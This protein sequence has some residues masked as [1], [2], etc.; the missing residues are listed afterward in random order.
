MGSDVGINMNSRSPAIEARFS[1]SPRTAANRLTKT[2]SFIGSNGFLVCVCLIGIVLRAVVYLHNRPFWTDEA[3]LALNIRARSAVDLFGKLDYCQAA[4][5]GFLVVE[6]YLTTGLGEG[7]L[8]LRFL[9]F[10]AGVC[11]VVIFAVFA[12]Q[13]LG[14]RATALCVILF[15]LSEA[16]IRYS[17]E[18]KQYSVDVFFALLIWQTAL[19]LLSSGVTERFRFNATALLAMIAPWFSFAS[20]LVVPAVLGVGSA[21]VLKHKDRRSILKWLVPWSLFGASVSLVYSL[22]LRSVSCGP[23]KDALMDD[24]AVPPHELTAIGWFASKVF[25]VMAF[26]G[27]FVPLATGIA[28]VC[29]LIGFWQLRQKRPAETMAICLPIALAAGG[30]CLSVYPFFGRFLLFAVPVILVLVAQGVQWLHS[31]VSGSRGTWISA[32]I[33][34]LL[35]WPRLDFVRWKG[36]TTRFRETEVRGALEYIGKNRQPGDLIY[37]Y[38]G[39]Y[40]PARYYCRAAGIG[41]DELTIGVPG[42][43][44]N[45]ELRDALLRAW[46]KSTKSETRPNK[47]VFE[48]YS[49]GDFSPQWAAFESDIKRL[50]GKGRVWVLFSLTNWLGSDEEKVFLHFLDKHGSWIKT[51]RLSGA[52]VFLYDFPRVL[53]WSKK[54]G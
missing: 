13:I 18:F 54:S 22:S 33:V 32:C 41:E 48:S 52:S 7:E 9:P 39:A 20:I 50:A 49:R 15:A 3:Q 46:E 34:L 51:K 53:R 44:W 16:L 36:D 35:L 17:T 2:W 29:L 4:P 14:S 1:G 26:P 42:Y 10:V 47:E 28:L 23:C 12:R 19:P 24:R 25:D 37:V 11:A 40:F 8:V 38:Y 31:K 27:G 43:W 30:A 21:T 45:S 5:P 6:K